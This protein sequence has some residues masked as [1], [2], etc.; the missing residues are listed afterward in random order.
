MT[1]SQSQV[2]KSERAK[3]LAQ[4]IAQAF[5]DTSQIDTYRRIC[6]AHNHQ[7]VY[8]AYREAVDVPLSK[9]KKSRSALFNY[10]IRKYEEK[11]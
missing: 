3:A 9:I 4:E 5:G 8:R 2:E 10:L 11:A 1:N 7:V 6:E